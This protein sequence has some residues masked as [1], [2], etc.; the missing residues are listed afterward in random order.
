MNTRRD[1]SGDGGEVRRLSLVKDGD[2]ATPTDNVESAPSR[3]TARSSD[4]PAASVA[5]VEA[6]S[7][8]V[9]SSAAGTSR[10]GRP[11]S[12]GRS[13]SEDDPTVEQD[14]QAEQRIT[15]EGDLNARAI[16]ADA[17][18][19]AYYRTLNGLVRSSHSSVLGP[20]PYTPAL[21]Y[22]DPTCVVVE[23]EPTTIETAELYARAAYP[24]F[25]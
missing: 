11:S 20:L 18:P 9:N 16:L 8:G 15:S 5:A 6:S 3:P 24:D 21:S 12:D 22:H 2:R 25:D 19:A 10:D 17:D 14:D 13:P 4:S 23:P 1:R 7:D